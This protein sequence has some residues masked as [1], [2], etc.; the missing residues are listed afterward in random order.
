MRDI[1]CQMKACNYLALCARPWAHEEDVSNL[2]AGVK[3]QE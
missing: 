3:A 1:R 2:F